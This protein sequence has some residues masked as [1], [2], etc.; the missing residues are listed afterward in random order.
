M[1]TRL[2]TGMVKRG[3][4]YH[5]CFRVNGRRIR[6]A[7]SR[8]MRTAI[9]LLSELRNRAERGDFGIIDNHYPWADLKQM[10]LRWAK[11]SISEWNQY[12]KDLERFERY[13]SVQ[14]VAEVNA[15]R[16]DAYRAHP[17]AVQVM[18][19]EIARSPFFQERKRLEAFEATFRITAELIRRGQENGEVRD[20]IDPG[21]AAFMF[22]GAV[23]MQLTA[24]VLGVTDV[25]NDETFEKAKR[26]AVTI[27]T[28]GILSR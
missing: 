1:A 8:N 20:D 4:T 27:I 23:E 15:A 16:I 18:V 6:K 5:A 21:N 7:L 3:D 22:Y 17:H 2:P 28:E 13:S 9:T 24:F 25:A 14:S 11:S 19:L 12:R 26:D 10:F